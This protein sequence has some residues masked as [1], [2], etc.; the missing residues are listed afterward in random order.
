MRD[1]PLEITIGDT[2]I[3]ATLISPRARVPAVLCVH[4]WGGSQDQYRARAR[5]IAALGCTCMT[6]D[7]RGHAATGS[8]R[9]RVTRA[10]NLA[11]TLAAYDVLASQPQVDPRAIAVIGSSYGAYLGTILTEQRPVR[12]LG[13]RAPALYEDSGW[14]LPKAELAKHQD[15]RAY[16]HR[17]LAADANRALRACHAFTGDIL[18]V[19]SEHDDIVPHAAIANYLDAARPARSITYRMLSG[20]DHGLSTPDAQQAYTDVLL[21]WLREML[22]APAPPA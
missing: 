6:F 17:A 13:L 18:I 2:T 14:E 22:P 21:A 1:E 4:G 19:E 10:D 3:A 7:L 5:A 11:D 9:D 8:A 15:L 16:R 12:W 20:V